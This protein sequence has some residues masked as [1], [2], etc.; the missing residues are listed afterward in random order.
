MV[1]ATELRKFAETF[2]TGVTVVTTRDNSGNFFGLTM[3]AV[4]SLSLDPPLYLICVDKTSMSLPALL[5]NCVFG[6]SVLNKDQGY[7]SRIFASQQ[8]DKFADV[9]YQIGETGVPLIDG[10]LASIECDVSRSYSEGDHIIIIGSVR[11]SRIRDGEPL[12]FYRGELSDFNGWPC[13]TIP[14]EFEIE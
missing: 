8:D 2:A 5:E 11:C 12:I 13:S 3:N 7:I 1:S 6:L 10:A 4:T 14:G 9:S